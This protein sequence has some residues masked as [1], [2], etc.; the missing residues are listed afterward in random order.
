[1][2]GELSALAARLT[3]EAGLL[4]GLPISAPG[5]G[6]CQLARFGRAATRSLRRAAVPTRRHC[7]Y[8]GERDVCRKFGDLAA[9]I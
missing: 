9:G 7:Q 1:M 6:Y 3:I 2:M 5:N 4:A 8:D